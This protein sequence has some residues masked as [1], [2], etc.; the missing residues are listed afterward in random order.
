MSV[1][2]NAGP[3][4]HGLRWGRSEGLVT[5]PL[6][7]VPTPPP[8]PGGGDGQEPTRGLLFSSRRRTSAS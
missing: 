7:P 3:R 1:S 8:A 4:S 6:S 2:G 5:A